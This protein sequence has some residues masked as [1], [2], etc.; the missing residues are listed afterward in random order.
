[1]IDSLP[2][3]LVLL[4]CQY[5][6]NEE[7]E[8]LAWTSRRFMQIVIRNLPTALQPRIPIDMLTISPFPVAHGEDL[9]ALT[10]NCKFKEGADNN[11]F[12]V[13]AYI[14]K[15]Q[16]RQ[17][18]A[19]DDRINL[20]L[21]LRWYQFCRRELKKN[22]PFDQC[23]QWEDFYMSN[24]KGLNKTEPFNKAV[25]LSQ[26]LFVRF[27]VKLFSITRCTT[28]QFW[29]VM[30]ALGSTR[31]TLRS[32]GIQSKH[33]H[34]DMPDMTRCENSSFLRIH[35]PYLMEIPAPVCTIATLSIPLFENT[36]INLMLLSDLVETL[37]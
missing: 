29:Q 19:E 6:S 20:E 1:M 21:F 12:I 8:T 31:G 15:A 30:E 16:E 18:F 25:P 27:N 28:R 23:V 2:T 13:S 9:F 17:Q 34:F 4:S 5:L 10:V 36:V 24:M 32:F 26:Q 22:I 14:R 7:V 37:Q 3:E 33:M 11:D 35:P